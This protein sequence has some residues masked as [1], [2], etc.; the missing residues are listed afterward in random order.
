MSGTAAEPGPSGRP[1]CFVIV[2]NISKKHNIG[3]LLRS[4]TAFGVKEVNWSL[5]SGLVQ[6]TA[7]V[8]SAV[9]MNGVLRTRDRKRSLRD[10]VLSTAT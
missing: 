10:L 7:V 4:C 2:Y 1:E 8:S 5:G 3:T 6:P 9:A